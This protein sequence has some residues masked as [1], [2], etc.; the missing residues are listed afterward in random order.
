MFPPKGYPKGCI[1]VNLDP[2]LLKI[3]Q[4]VQLCKKICPKKKICEKSQ[5]LTKLG[6]K[7]SKK[8]H[9]EIGPKLFFI[10]FEFLIPF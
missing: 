9:H 4:N 5:K 1:S 2:P 7:T 10:F 6:L 3:T 8:S